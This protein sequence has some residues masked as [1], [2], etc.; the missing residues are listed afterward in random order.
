MRFIFMF[1]ILS[2]LPLS[3]E[4]ASAPEGYWMTENEQA[5]I[6]IEKCD[7]ELCGYLYWI[8]DQSRQFD[9][10]NPNPDLQTRPLCGLKILTKFQQNPRNTKLWD[11]GEIYKSDEGDTYSGYI[12]VDSNDEIYLRGYV[13]IS[14]FGK[15]QIW[16]RVNK[17]DYKAC[18][19]P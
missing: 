18:K 4:A 15:S 7:A 14:L 11:D 16:T 2:I 19:Q 5:I 13:G 12:R 8:K 10:Q 9:D 1:L 3:A 6:K 17:T